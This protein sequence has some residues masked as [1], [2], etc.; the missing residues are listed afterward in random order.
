MAELQ[1]FQN[2]AGNHPIGNPFALSYN[3]QT[4]CNIGECIPVLCDEVAP[5]DYFRIGAECGIRLQPLNAPIND[6]LVV[7][8]DYFFVPYRLLDK[9]WVKFI[10]GG[11]NGDYVGQLPVMPWSSK[12]LSDV[13]DSYPEYGTVNKVAVKKTLWDYFGHPL[14]TDLN[15]YT[16][17]NNIPNIK[18]RPLL[19]PWIAANMIKWYYYTDQNLNPEYM[20]NKEWDDLPASYKYSNNIWSRPYK[21]DYF[22]SALPFQQRGTAPSLPLSG[23]LPVVANYPAGTST[24][25]LPNGKVSYAIDSQNPRGAGFLW[26]AGTVDSN[27]DNIS[28]PANGFLYASADGASSFTVSEMRQ[29]FA[30]QK[31]MELNARGGARYNEFL[32]SHFAISPTD[33][34]LQRPE[35][36][37][38]L[39]APILVSEV[40]QQS[41]TASGGALGDVAGRGITFSREHLENYKA[42]EF[43]VI[44]GF[45]SV[46]PSQSYFQGINR[47]WL[48]RSRFDF[49]FPEFANLSEQGIY[50]AELFVQDD[51]GDVDDDFLDTVN[52]QVFGFQGIYD[53]MRIKQNRITGMMRN[54]LDYWHLARK[55]A[56]APNLNE[57]FITVKSSDFNRIFAVQ[58]E[59]QVIVYF[60]NLLDGTSR[61]MPAVPD[62]GL[63]DH[64]Y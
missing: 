15:W 41:S 64:V 39:S 37:G 33:R 19:Y 27:V 11:T 61:P 4:T 24:S 29:V 34:T 23:Y 6:R 47:Q 17:G 54:E 60:R 22:T 1:L 5:G 16:D 51:S 42:E 10:T 63:V 21:K 32:Q 55:F 3:V 48:R 13:D 12:T 50:N 53:E 58:D 14:A 56:N 36:L 28:S 30:I 57:D 46:M 9:N 26:E 7:D 52:G 8:V 25:P 38:R 18:A 62:P 49:F 43:G 40:L 2:V 59:D 31:W 20:D 44:L 45:L 35:Y